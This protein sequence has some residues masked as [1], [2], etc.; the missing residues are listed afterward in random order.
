MS[1]MVERIARAIHDAAHKGLD[2]DWPR[3]MRIAQ[4]RAAIEA[5]RQPTDEMLYSGRWPNDVMGE[6]WQAMI[7]AALGG[8]NG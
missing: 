4:A 3:E 1:E 6:N 5:M 2:F 7:D 8:G